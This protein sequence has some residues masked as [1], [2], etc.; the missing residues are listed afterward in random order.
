MLTRISNT[1]SRGLSLS[2]FLQYGYLDALVDF[3]E[4]DIRK[5]PG[6]VT[7]QHGHTS[8]SY[9]AR[10]CRTASKRGLS[11]YPWRHCCSKHGTSKSI[12]SPWLYLDSSTLK[13]DVP[14]SSQVNSLFVIPHRGPS[15]KAKITADFKS[16]IRKWVASTSVSSGLALLHWSEF[17]DDSFR[18]FLEDLGLNSLCAGFGGFVNSTKSINYSGGRANHL[19]RLRHILLNCRHIHFLYPSTV[20]LYAAALGLNLELH[21][22]D[23]D[24]TSRMLYPEDT[25]KSDKSAANLFLNESRWLAQQLGEI[26]RLDEGQKKVFASRLLGSEYM[27]TK[28]EISEILM[29][30]PSISQKFRFAW[31]G[32]R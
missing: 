12:G 6:F 4:L 22:Q 23:I 14:L 29:R 28:E 16:T 15:T 17:L 31:Y 5:L 10:A 2:N 27:R 18:N 30:E 13:F 11:F 20:G 19:F 25:G 9:V 24:L 26:S 1:Q 7:S 3:A 8:P 21:F 32:L